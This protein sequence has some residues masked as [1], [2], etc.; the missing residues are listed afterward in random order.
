VRF[1]Y[2]GEPAARMAALSSDTTDIVGELEPTNIAVVE[3]NS[4]LKVLQRPYGADAFFIMHTTEKPFDDVRVRKA[5]KLTIDRPGLV[6]AVLQGRG[7]VMNDQPVP[8]ESPDWVNLPTPQRDIAKAKEL[9]SAAGY[10]NGLDLT[11]YVMPGGPGYVEA[12]TAMQEMMKPAG[13]NLK[14]ERLT[15]DIY[16]TEAYM[17]KPFFVSYWIPTDLDYVFNLGFYSSSPYNE[18]GWQS[19]ELDAQIDALASESDLGKRKAILTKIQTLISEEG[20]VLIPYM[21]QQ[22]IGMRREVQG[23]EPFNYRVFFHTAWLSQG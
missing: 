15:A 22:F 8:P 16:W 10:A 1:V 7:V 5:V 3:G 21:A 17:Q 13:I 2:I 23:I 4:A 19:P 18:S 6:Q 20:A 9:L 11:L 12:A 14:V